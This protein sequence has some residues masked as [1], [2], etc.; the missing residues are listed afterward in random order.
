MK[1]IGLFIIFTL[2]FFQADFSFAGEKEEAMG[3][4]LFMRYCKVCHGEKGM[5]DGVNSESESMDPIPQDLCDIEKPYMMEKDNKYLIEAIQLGGKRA[6]VTPLM[7]H[8]DKTLSEYE[9]LTLAAFIRTMHKHNQPPID[10]KGAST[11]K[12]KIDVG[13][14]KIG[15]LTRADRKIG[16]R[17]YKKNGC[18]GCHSINEFG[19][20]SGPELSTIGGKLNAQKLWQIILDPASVNG[21]SKMPAYDIKE[22]NGSLLVGYLLTLKE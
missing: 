7:P 14:I 8:W 2:T 16:K 6:F 1:I 5:G 18:Q 4:Q 10:F 9:I 20:T 22:E 21:D 11:D 12:P 19:G 3:K 17:L 13:E 15:E